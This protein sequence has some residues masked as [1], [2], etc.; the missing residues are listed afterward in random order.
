MRFTPVILSLSLAFGLTASVLHSAPSP[1]MD[2]RAAALESEGR[3]ALKAGNVQAAIDDFEAALA[4]QP[5]N[6]T[7]TLGLAAA[8]RQQGMQ[9][10]ALHYYRV[11][12]T[13]D[14][15]NLDA[16]A[17]E[18]AALVEKGAVEKARRSLAHLKTLCN[19]CAQSH[20][21][22]EAIARGPAPKVVSAEDVTPA[23]TVS[24]N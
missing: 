15:Q 3:A 12:L 5:G 1:I 7:I 13:Y 21:L 24:N 16:I 4:I 19:D 8:N 11:A 10:K 20:Q 2:P 22:A 9:G 17:G 14:S 6:L 23:P 18:G